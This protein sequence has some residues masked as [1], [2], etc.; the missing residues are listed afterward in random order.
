MVG[1]HTEAVQTTN[2]ATAIEGV[3][4]YINGAK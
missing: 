1:H 4:D 3:A 2:A